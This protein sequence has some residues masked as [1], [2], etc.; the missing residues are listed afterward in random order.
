VERFWVDIRVSHDDS[1]YR[2]FVGIMKKGTRVIVPPDYPTVEPGEYSLISRTGAL[3]LSGVC[4]ILDE[5]VGTL[6]EH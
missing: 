4:E 1:L 5:A 3:P 6:K 2:D